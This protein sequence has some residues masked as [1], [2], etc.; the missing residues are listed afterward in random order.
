MTMTIFRR[1]LIAVG[2]VVVAAIVVIMIVVFISPHVGPQGTSSDVESAAYS[3][4]APV[5]HAATPTA[6]GVSHLPDPDWVRSVAAKTGIPARA[7]AAY[8]GVAIDI[9]NANPACGIGWNTLAA[10]GEIE[11]RHGTIF[12]G[13][14]GADGT[15]SPPIFGV[16]LDGVAVASIPD[17]D[18]GAI[19]GDATVDRAVGPMQMI[20]ASWKNWHIDASGDGVES[21]QNIDD[22]TMA[23]GHYLC[24]AGQ[25][26]SGAEGWRKAVLAYNG[27]G[28]YLQGVI[29]WSN[30]YADKAA[31]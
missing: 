9:Q 26:L 30:D 2:A 6:A 22:E 28:Q 24:R 15:A 27:S 25:N 13:S 8:A 31:D 20:P 3:A 21:A 12:G 17:S 10:I 1:V 14:I 7:L 19:D 11:S 5:D 23:A 16:A 29:R 18:G 4:A